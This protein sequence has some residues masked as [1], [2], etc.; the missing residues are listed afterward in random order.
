MHRECAC[1]LLLLTL[2]LNQRLIQCFS[3][4][5]WIGSEPLKSVLQF[6]TIRFVSHNLG[7]LG[8]PPFAACFTSGPSATFRPD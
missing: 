8:A 1:K 7:L 2:L 3:L 5:R 6:K 4:T